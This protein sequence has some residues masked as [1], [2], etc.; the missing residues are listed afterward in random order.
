MFIIVKD[1][2]INKFLIKSKNSI[3][4][5]SRGKLRLI[6]ISGNCQ[7]DNSMLQHDKFK[8]TKNQS[9]DFQFNT[10]MVKIHAI[11]RMSKTHV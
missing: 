7:C 8:A 1:Q 9:L 6:Q 3:N 2:S 5:L 4:E 11:C 10:S